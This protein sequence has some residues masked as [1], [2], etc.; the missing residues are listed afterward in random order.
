M[1]FPIISSWKKGIGSKLIDIHLVE[2]LEANI[3][4]IKKENIKVNF[5][6]KIPNEWK[7]DVILFAVK[8]QDFKK[9][10]EEV[11]LNNVLFKN[12]VSIM[13]GITTN[14]IRSYLKTQTS[15]TRVM[16][17][18]AVEVNLGVNCIFHSSNSK[19]LFK[20]NIK[21]QTIKLKKKGE[22]FTVLENQLHIVVPLSK[23]AIFHETKL[24]END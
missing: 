2:K 5:Y 21:S 11:N 23:I 9:V 16:P 8:P 18:L 19:N 15:V 17:N 4:K 14:K 6:K 22:I 20:K 13:A 12:I 24:R 1:G 3:N 7:G 10:A